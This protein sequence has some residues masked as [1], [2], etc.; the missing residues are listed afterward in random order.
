MIT[1]IKKKPDEAVIIISAW[2]TRE[3]NYCICVSVLQNKFKKNSPIICPQ[4]WL[5]HTPK[6]YLCYK[7]L[8]EQVHQTEGV[9]NL[10]K[11][12]KFINPF[13]ILHS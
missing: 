7:K 1:S 11:N 12:P 9:I 10:T 8:S 3:N 6:K 4:Y 5:F 13:Y 2:K